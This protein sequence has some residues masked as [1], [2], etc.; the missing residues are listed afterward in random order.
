[1]YAIVDIAGQQFKVEKGQEL[2][3]HRIDAEKGAKVDFEKVMLID[4]EGKTTIGTP[5][6]EGALVQATVME[7]LRGDKVFVFKKKRRKGFKKFNG[8]RQYL[9]LL[10][11]EDILE[12]GKVSKAKPKKA[13]VPAEEP[14]AA[15]EEAANNA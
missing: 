3:V 1:M 4:H 5:V 10:K 6:V 12:K 7:H 8:H 13:A 9:S 15:A 14:V 2:F 11:I